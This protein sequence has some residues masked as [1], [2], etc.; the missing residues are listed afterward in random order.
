MNDEI[1]PAASSS[2]DSAQ[3]CKGT[4]K[5]CIAIAI[6]VITGVIRIL[7]ELTATS[8]AKVEKDAS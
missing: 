1:V 7:E 2:P 6:V 8:S 3:N 4:S 5:E